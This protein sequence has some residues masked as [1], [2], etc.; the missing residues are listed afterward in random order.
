[1]EGVIW[2][3]ESSKRVG[4]MGAPGMKPLSLKVEDSGSGCEGTQG[5]VGEDGGGC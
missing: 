4:I 3:T 1:M 2:I 5:L